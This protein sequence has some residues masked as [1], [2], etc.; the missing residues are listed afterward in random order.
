MQL[1]LITPTAFLKIYNSSR[2]I[3]MVLAHQVLRDLVYANFYRNVKGYKILDNSLM[4]NGH[5]AVPLIELLTAAET[6]QAHEIV[7]PDAFCDAAQTLKLVNHALTH[8]EA[9]GL[10]HRE[11]KIAAV[12]QGKTPSDWIRCF[13][14][15]HAN[16][17]IDVIHIPKVMDV[18]WPYAGR[19]GLL[20]H[21]HNFM[22]DTI[23]KSKKEI[24]LL[25]VWSSVLDLAYSSSFFWVRSLDTAL[26]IHAG[27]NGIRLDL[28]SNQPKSKRPEH[29]FNVPIS[30]DNGMIALNIAIAD[31]LVKR[32]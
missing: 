26:P 7:L 8:L 28:L 19:Y 1:A 30:Q 2:K 17:R 21:I 3:H 11:V 31:S 27:L 23:V 10:P 12:A 4:E 20:T 18:I 5:K 15:L 13:K 14:K 24:H 25:G 6:V 9:N 22:L 16:P 29:Y 32:R